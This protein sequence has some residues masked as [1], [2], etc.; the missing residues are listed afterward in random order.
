MRPL[1]L[2]VKTVS[3]ETLKRLEKLGYR[4]TVILK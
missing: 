2:K 1:V 4:V 3:T